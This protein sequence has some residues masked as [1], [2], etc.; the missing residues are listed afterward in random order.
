MLGARSPADESRGVEPPTDVN[1]SFGE[2]PSAEA[3][4]LAQ[5]AGLFPAHIEPHEAEGGG[6][7]WEAMSEIDM[8]DVYTLD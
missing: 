5:F 4:V 8:S 7:Q 1:G 2:S 6:A 3:T